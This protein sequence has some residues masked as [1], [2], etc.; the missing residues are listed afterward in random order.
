[1][2]QPVIVYSTAGCSDCNQVKQLLTNQGIP[3]EVRD[4]MASAV[5]QEEVEKLGF[6]GIPVTVSG[7]RAVKGF[8][9]PELEELIAAAR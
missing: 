5:Y 2:S 7:D 1:M 3:F 9:L 4:I 6:M 8:N